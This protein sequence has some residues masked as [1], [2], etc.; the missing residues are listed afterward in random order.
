MSAGATLWCGQFLLSLLY[1]DVVE[2][3]TM[4]SHATMVMNDRIELV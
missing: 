4:L 1:A 2:K 3:S